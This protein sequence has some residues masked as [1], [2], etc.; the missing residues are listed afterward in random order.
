MSKPPREEGSSALSN[1]PTAALTPDDVAAARAK[2]AGRDRVET[3]GIPGLALLPADPAQVVQKAAL[4]EMLGDRLGLATTQIGRARVLLAR[5]DVAA[6]A[7]LAAAAEEVARS[8]GGTQ[9]R[10]DALL[11]TAEVALAEGNGDRARSVL[12]EVE[13]T[14]LESDEAALGLAAAILAGRLLA[15]SSDGSLAARRAL[16][17][18]ARRATARG[19]TLIALEARVEAVRLAVDPGAG[20]DLAERAALTADLRRR[21]LGRLERRLGQP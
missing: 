21:G 13:K 16:A 6:A 18:I 12:Q 20:R 14:A 15:L 5:G 10:A 7:K 3:V 17:D 2:S 4:D 19:Q 1:E 11:V 9:S 8:E